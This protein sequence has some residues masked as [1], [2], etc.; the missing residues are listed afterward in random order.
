ML[1]MFFGT[2][3]ILFTAVTAQASAEI[4]LNPCFGLSGKPYKKYIGF[5]AID[6]QIIKFKK[7]CS[8]KSESFSGT[9]Q[10]FLTKKGI[11]SQC[12]DGTAHI[13]PPQCDGTTPRPPVPRPPQ[14]GPTPPPQGGQDVPKFIFSK[15][16][17]LDFD[18]RLP[19]QLPSHEA[20]YAGYYDYLGYVKS[21]MQDPFGGMPSSAENSDK[22][23]K[24]LLRKIINSTHISLSGQ[25]DALSDKLCAQI[26]VENGASCASRISFS[27][28]Q[29]RTYLF[30]HKDFYLE[31]DTTGEFSVT[32]R[33]CERRYSNT[34]LADFGDAA[35]AQR[36]GPKSVPW[37]ETANTE[38]LWP[39]N[40]FCE[41]EST[42]KCKKSSKWRG[43]FKLQVA[44][45]H[46]LFPTDQ[47]VNGARGHL[48]FGEV[49]E[50]NLKKS[51]CPTADD[52]RVRSTEISPV[53]SGTGAADGRTVFQP[54]AAIR[55]DIARALFYFSLYYKRAI[56]P[57]EEAYLRKWHKED[58]A[59]AAEKR[60]H[61][62]VFGAQ[63]NRNPFI[64]VPSLVDAISDF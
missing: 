7:S 35:K 13:E 14:P 62:A 37:H 43:M 4:I 8:T 57:T 19:N 28:R 5:Q 32:D 16:S 31:E 12:P 25:S 38:H 58:P 39:K 45:L 3:A 50:A 20:Y 6:G 15:V 56:D 49:S 60:R 1:K 30:G 59:D 41:I 21:S 29:A 2:L 44:D 34:D 64:D 61:E 36:F 11:L 9:V 27:Y 48:K 55:G 23:L 22:A 18:W 10:Q 63:K 17:K 47:K 26:E 40:Y 46:H 53:G 52:F 51:N 54:Q 33:Y 24:S 42:S